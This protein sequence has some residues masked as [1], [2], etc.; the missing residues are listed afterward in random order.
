[1]LL[2]TKVLHLM[3]LDYST[4]LTFRSK[5]YVPSV[6]TPSSPK[7]ALR[8]V[9]VSLPTHSLKE[10]PFPTDTS[11]LTTTA[12]TEELL[13]RTSCDTDGYIPFTF[14]RDPY[15]SLFLCLAPRMFTFCNIFPATKKVL[16]G[17]HRCS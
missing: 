16:I 3:T 5:W 10:Q 15:G 6:R 8:P 17:A 14:Q 4:V 9:M 2:D 7:L 1:M 12:T 11:Q 13:L